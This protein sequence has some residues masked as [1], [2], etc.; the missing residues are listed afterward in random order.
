MRH[1]SHFRLLL[2]LIV[3]VAVTAG[4]QEEPS[5]AAP[6][7]DEI[8]VPR[9]VT[10]RRLPGQVTLAKLSNGLTVIVQENHVAPVAT[11]RCYVKN[12]GS[13]YEGKYLGAGLSHVLEHVVSG[14]STKKRAEKE[15][16]KIIDRFGGASNAYTSS[17]LTA[18]FIDCPARDV[19]TAIDLVADSMQNI[20]FEP[21][22]FERELKVV[23]RELADGEV[24]RGRVKWQMLSE[25]LY[26]L[27]PIRYPTIGYLDVLNGTSNETIM[28]FY[29][30]RY[31][32]NNQV[33]VVV[34]DVNT[35]ET[36]DMVA[37]QWAGTRR[38]RETFV[39]LPEEPEQLSPREAVREMDGKT[40][41]LVLAWPTVDLSHPD[42]YPLDVAAYILSEGD[43]SRMVRRLK[44]G[45]QLVLSVSSA[46]YTPH[47]AN[48]FF[49]IFASC[50]A[51]TWR[52]APEEI[53]RDVYRLR[54][55]F[56]SPSELVKAK[57][58]K[59]AELVFDQQTVQQA[60]GSLGRSYISTGD[61]LFDHRYV[62]NIQKVT[63]EQIRAVARRYVVPERLNRIVI[64]PPG[65][66]P[67]SADKGKGRSEGEVQTHRLSNGLRVLIKRH[68]QLPM[69]NIQAYVLGAS[70]V[71][72]VQT[73]GRAALVGRMLDKGTD[74]HSAEEIAEYFD[75]IG[76]KLSFRAG[77][78]TVY[79]RATVLRD[80]FV[81]AAELF[82][83][84]LTRPTF[85][86]DQ[87]AKAQTLALGAIARRA[88]NPQ[89]EIFETF[90]D[91][92]PSTTPYHVVQGGKEATV[93]QLTAKDLR[94]YHAKHFVPSNMIV[95]VFGDVDPAETL[96]L[97]E[98]TFGRMKPV[99]DFKRVG[100]H[101]TNSIPKTLVRHKKTKKSTGM[102]LMG[103]AGPSIFDKKDYAALIVLDAVMSG[104]SYPGGWL[105]NDLRGEGLVYYV[106]AF[107][108]TGPSPG[109]FA[110][111]AQ[112]HPNKIDEVIARIRKNVD[113]A[114]AGEISDDEF[115]TAVQMV[116]S[117]HA[118][119]NTTI[120]EQAQQA[121]LDELYGLGYAYDKTFDSRIKAVTRDDVVRVAGKYLKQYVLVTSSPGA[122]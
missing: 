33:F 4:A 100:F 74:R 92:V 66:A 54:D 65:G 118:Q 14:G 115:N 27:H 8:E 108:I 69:V 10:V 89:S 111:L 45:R 6:K 105:H 116:L 46:S 77:R 71:D 67:E 58:Q 15:I 28:E 114:K 119:D 20:I 40:Y 104:Y 42:L 48:G 72:T 23:R 75:S 106:H 93:R 90:Y 16:E 55:E 121:A 120:G 35:Q 78:F 96:S 21:S 87:F 30:E 63:A 24:S 122:K 98:R 83:E 60:A 88:G 70:L 25:T 95:T 57:K 80:D 29:R 59:A 2:V 56:V 84:C 31:V 107:Q 9:Y 39:P 11:V 101:R 91:N 18:Y 51:K 5:P 12:T 109:Y 112:T 110:V 61:P 53:L 32:P 76:G 43:S 17:N 97:L 117:L 38:A 99:P 13:A 86:G 41:D 81:K 44:Y 19:M 79:G 37:K 52:Q 64:A 3:S 103:Y 94:A 36:L 47:F 113:R 82:A 50:T 85:P 34:G 102:V 49:A 62:E 22:E 26:T 73:A 7:A 68:S 1:D